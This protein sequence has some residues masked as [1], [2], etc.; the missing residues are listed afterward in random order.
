MA[1]LEADPVTL[2]LTSTGDLDIINFGFDSGLTAVKNGIQ[3]RLELV[4]GEWFADLDLGVDYFGAIFGKAYTEIG[5]RS[6]ITD[7]LLDTPGVSEV[8]SLELTVDDMAR[9]L[10]IDWEVL[11]E[12]DDIP[13]T[14][15][16]PIS[17]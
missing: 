3:A 14:G 9:T 13:L 17:V 12:F 7:A 4:A 8:T 2:K 11:V 5:A 10:T 16:L 6:E 1:L 15:T